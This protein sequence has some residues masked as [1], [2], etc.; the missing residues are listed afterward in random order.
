M[1]SI[2]YTFDKNFKLYIPKDKN[3]I[4]TDITKHFNSVIENGAGEILL[5]SIDKDLHW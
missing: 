5:Q 2:D 3:F 4:K 1:A